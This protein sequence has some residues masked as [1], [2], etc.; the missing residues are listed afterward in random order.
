MTGTDFD[1]LLTAF[2][3][4]NIEHAISAV[5]EGYILLSDQL[6]QISA[7]QIYKD[8]AAL[9]HT[10]NLPQ[11]S[12]LIQ[13]KA[14]LYNLALIYA[15]SD[16]QFIKTH[17]FKQQPIEANGSLPRH[18]QNIDFQIDDMD[19]TCRYIKAPN[20]TAI[21][22]FLTG[23]YSTVAEYKDIV[24]NVLIP[25]GISCVIAQHPKC[26]D[27]W[28]DVY[29]SMPAHLIKIAK[30]LNTRDHPLFWASHSAGCAMFEIDRRENENLQKLINNDLSGAV[31]IHPYFGPS[32]ATKQFNPTNRSIF[33]WHAS[34]NSARRYGY[35]WGDIIFT[36]IN[37]RSIRQS[38]NLDKITPL[39]SETLALTEFVETHLDVIKEDPN[40]IMNDLD[41]YYFIMG[42][43]DHFVCSNA[44]QAVA[45][46]A[47]ATQV[48][49]LGG[50]T[51]TVEQLQPVIQELVNERYKN[52]PHHNRVGGYNQFPILTC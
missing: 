39:H 7:E 51:P 11:I 38:G 27:G 35:T 5:T 12:D 1:R 36:L 22:P 4:T 34:S 41:H 43:N 18:W 20:E 40:Y 28:L 45:E 33:N 21:M 6:S 31:H 42:N 2:D 10:L 14:L 16:N 47:G 29:Q 52:T 32:N 24:E 37:A 50:H 46:H 30:D 23:F 19:I 3:G 49:V 9:A 8:T 48:G 17:L 44:Q 13:D 25:N 26:V 15:F